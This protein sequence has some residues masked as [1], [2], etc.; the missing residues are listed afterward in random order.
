MFG[1]KLLVK[2]LVNRKIFKTLNCNTTKTALKQYRQRD[3]QADRQRQPDKQ[4]YKQTVTI[5]IL[6]FYKA[7]NYAFRDIWVFMF[8]LSLSPNIQTLTYFPNGNTNRQ[9][10]KQ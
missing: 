8:F 9:T 7:N 10:D 4:T 5:T 2:A 6:E 1:L 3:R